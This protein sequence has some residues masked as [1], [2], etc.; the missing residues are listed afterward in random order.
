MGPES[1]FHVVSGRH[2]LIYD[3]HVRYPNEYVTREGGTFE[4]SDHDGL[5][6]VDRA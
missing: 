3:S 5:L 2:S 1:A 6:G 4:V